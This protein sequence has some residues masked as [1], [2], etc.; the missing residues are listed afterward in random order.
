MNSKLIKKEKITKKSRIIKREDDFSFILK[1]S[2]CINQ[3]HS[4]IK[5]KLLKYDLIKYEL[6]ER[7]RELENQHFD[8]F[9]KLKIIK[10][11]N[12]YNDF[13]KFPSSEYYCKN[14]APFFISDDKKEDLIREITFFTNVN[15]F[16]NDK[17][18]LSKCCNNKENIIINSEHYEVC[19]ECGTVLNSYIDFSYKYL[20]YDAIKNTDIKT[21]P[22]YKKS[23]HFRDKLNQ[24]LS[25][26]KSNIPK[27]II[28]SVKKQLFVN[29]I[30]NTE[31]ITT[32]IIKEILKN[33]GLEKYYQ[34]TYSIYRIITNTKII[35][36]DNELIGKLEKMFDSVTLSFEK[37]K[38]KGR[39]SI[40]IYDYTIHKLLEILGFHIY[41]KHFKPPKNF[42]KV[43]EYDCLWKKICEDLQWE[44]IPTKII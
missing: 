30:K 9:I 34:S 32:D 42:E 44:F 43:I 5:N 41:K 12:E 21:K 3:I 39:K 23:N 26:T 1:K 29:N 36:F 24:K 4:F 2:L 20:S 33:L 17:L 19:A 38:N 13:K 11:E 25:E 31:D 7:I 6:R 27:N 16:N 40:F 8:K 35:N 37:I 10:Y 14:I 22:V 15:F 18:D 28:E